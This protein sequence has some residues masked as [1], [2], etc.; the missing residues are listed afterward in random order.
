MHFILYCT[1][2]HIVHF[3]SI[4]IIFVL[5]LLFLLNNSVKKHD[6]TFC[7]KIIVILTNINILLKDNVYS[8]L[9]MFVQKKT[10]VGNV[11]PQINFSNISEILKR[12]KTSVNF[13]FFNLSKYYCSGD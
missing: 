9:K 8:V 5:T 7:Q 10:I 11:V 4:H 2:F 12:R 3:V 6:I 13:F 1:Y